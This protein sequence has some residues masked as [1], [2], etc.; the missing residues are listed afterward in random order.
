MVNFARVRE[1]LELF[2]GSRRF[3]ARQPCAVLKYQ[4]SSRVFVIEVMLI[5][6]PVYLLIFT[7]ALLAVGLIVVIVG[8]RRQ[9]HAVGEF[10]DQLRRLTAA[11]SDVG[12]ID[13]EG[14]PESL[15]RLAA[16][17][18][19]LL[20]SVERRG[21]DLQGREQLFQR[22]VETVHYAVLV[23]RERILFANSRFLALLGLTAAD[24]VGRQ[25]SDF[26]GPEYVELVDTNLRRRL[27]GEPVA[28]RYEVE[29]IGAHG[30]VTRVELSSALIDSDGEAA[31]LLTALEML[32]EASTPPNGSAGRPRAVATLDAMGES[33]V[34]VDAGGRIDYINT[35]AES[36][37]GQRLDQV[38]GKSF[39]D[40]A[41]LVDEADRRSLGDPVRMA[42]T[43]G[44]R[45][46]MGRRAVLVPA[47][48]AVERYVERSVTPLKSEA[49]DTLGVV[50]V[51]H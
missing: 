33:V 45:V 48:G 41:S 46:T 19:Q 2:S 8:K 32:P 37:L 39:P 51:L 10:S 4:A 49:G 43:A 6:S 20:E 34:T 29:L 18:N 7:S 21:A 27:D 47:N 30:E 25:L 16:A 40:V 14:K 5:L 44:G 31:L 17:V 12:R 1:S 23:H 22:L 36:L 24:V 26:V 42:L 3:T 38:V 28:E 35:A 50:L 11:S 9:E 13:L 15:E